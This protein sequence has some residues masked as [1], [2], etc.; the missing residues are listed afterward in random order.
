MISWKRLNSSDLHEFFESD[1]QAVRGFIEI[2]KT[3]WALSL[4]F[5]FSHERMHHVKEFFHI[6]WLSFLKVVRFEGMWSNADK[7]F[8]PFQTSERIPL[9]QANFPCSVHKGLVPSHGYCDATAT[10]KPWEMNRQE[11]FFHWVPLL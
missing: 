6:Y 9:A 8:F 3:H 11:T 5:H 2:Q 10:G 4:V 7:T 1:L